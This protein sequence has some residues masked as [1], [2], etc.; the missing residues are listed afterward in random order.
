MN[1]WWQ[2][3]T[4]CSSVGESP[5]SRELGRAYSWSV[6]LTKRYLALCTRSRK[7]S[8][9]RLRSR[10][11][12]RLGILPRDTASETRHP[13]RDTVYFRYTAPYRRRNNQVE[14]LRCDRGT[15]DPANPLRLYL[16]STIAARQASAA[17][18]GTLR[19][20]LPCLLAV[21]GVYSPNPALFFIAAGLL[22]HRLRFAATG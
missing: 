7:R 8:F 17:G 18:S 5:L 1:T 12:Y 13:T 16:A 10:S 22:A 9:D 21:K 2:R 20:I 19:T 3:L 4:K 15:R 14:P 11:T 6:R